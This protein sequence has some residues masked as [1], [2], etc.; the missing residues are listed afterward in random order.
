ML[1]DK[2]VLKQAK[3]KI[4]CV[5]VCV[6]WRETRKGHLVGEPS[7]QVQTAVTWPQIPQ[8]KG[9]VWRWLRV[10]GKWWMN[11]RK[12]WKEKEVNGIKENV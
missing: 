2:K 6:C 1:E 7:D 8:R 9:A 4:L 10:V 5:C 3:F 12:I 11:I